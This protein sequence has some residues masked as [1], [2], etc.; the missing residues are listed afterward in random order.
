VLIKIQN[1]RKKNNMKISVIIPTYNRYILLKRA[2]ASVLIQSHGI[3]EVIVID[4]G[5]TD[6]TAQ[7][8]KDF[9]Q[10]KY[11][12]Q[13]NSGVSSARNLGV[14]NAAHEWIAFLDSDDTWH[15]DKLKAQVSFHKQ[16]PDILMS[17]TDERWIRDDK[18]V[19]IPKKFKKYGGE[20]FE[21]SL[22]FCNI[23][24]SSALLHKSLLDEIGLFDESLEVC[25][26]YDLWL[27]IA[28]KNPIGLIDKKLITKYAGHKNQLSFKYWGM[29]RFRVLALEKL[30]VVCENVQKS[31]LI[32]NEL[33]KKYALLL[34]GAKKYDR[35]QDIK[36]YEKKMENFK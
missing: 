26:D 24:P 3:T 1:Q 12:Y 28:L 23:A 16:N 13:K 7:I 2:V 9:P 33:R 29:D 5:S 32:K 10:I 18:E 8:Q 19:K 30:L 36:F 20:I 17:Y 21:E 14:L 4:D 22:A 35:I 31:D 25:E 6:N 27:R 11:I 34:L 15:E